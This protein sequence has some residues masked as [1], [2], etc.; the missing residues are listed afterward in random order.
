MI[1]GTMSGAMKFASAQP[2]PANVQRR[3]PYAASPPRNRA[4]MD[5][6]RASTA[7]VVIASIQRGSPKKLSYQRSDRPG[8]GKVNACADEKD[9]GTTMTSG[10][11]RKTRPK[12]PAAANSRPRQGALSV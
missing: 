5:E 1:V 4:T 7:D 12:M 9:M 8:G 6:I 11:V 10:T 3:R 2:R